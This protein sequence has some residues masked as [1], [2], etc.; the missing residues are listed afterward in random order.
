VLSKAERRQGALEAINGSTLT[1]IVRQVLDDRSIEVVDWQYIRLQYLAPDETQSGKRPQANTEST[2]VDGA[3]ATAVSALLREF[4]KG[5]Q[6]GGNGRG[7]YRFTGHARSETG[8]VPWSLI[9]KVQ[10]DRPQ[11]ERQ[12]YQSGVLADLPSDFEMPACYC[13]DEWLD[14][15]YWLWLEDACD[16]IGDVWPVEQFGLASRH[17]AHFNGAYLTGRALPD[18]PWLS[19]K[20]SRHWDATAEV[21]RQLESVREH[22]LIARAYYPENAEGVRRLFNDREMFRVAL[23]Q[24]PHTLCHLDAQRSNLVARKKDGNDCTVGIDWG[25]PG[26]API[27]ME[28]AQFSTNFRSVRDVDLNQLQILSDIVFEE[29]LAGLR[30]V[31]WEGDRQLLRLGYTASAALQNGLSDI[32][33]LRGG[34]DPRKYDRMK[35]LWGI[36]RWRRIWIEEENYCGLFLGL[37]MRPGG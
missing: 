15:D 9:L 11:R 14:G 31:G 2:D 3:L 4:D 1:P 13:V 30:E 34:V 33:P 18:E 26:I 6:D 35:L 21:M 19:R 23:E 37:G 24:L 25:R 32:W 12:A 22:P 5:E 20:P 27:G 29:Y 8:S 17:L 36:G 7:V 16:D 28:I 10:A